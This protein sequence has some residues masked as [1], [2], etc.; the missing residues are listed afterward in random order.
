[1]EILELSGI[2]EM[3]QTL[4]IGIFVSAVIVGGGVL[5]VIG[6][7]IWSRARDRHK[8]SLESVLIE[9]KLPRNNEVKIDS[10]EQHFS[11]FASMPGAEG[12]LGFSKVPDSVTF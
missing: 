3:V 4:V 12:I 11:S 2:I 1:M 5:S 10:A 8:R 9:V 7:G 6:A